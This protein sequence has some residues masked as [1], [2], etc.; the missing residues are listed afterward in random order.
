MSD[1]TTTPRPDGPT[2]QETYTHGYETALTLK[3]HAGRPAAVQAK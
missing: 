2:D 1:S 3:L